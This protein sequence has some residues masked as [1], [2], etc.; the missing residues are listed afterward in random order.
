MTDDN[1]VLVYNCPNCAGDLLERSS[2]FECSACGREYP[3]LFGI[4]DF[5]TRPDRYLSLAEERAKAARLHEFGLNHSFAELL[6]FYYEITDDVP[7]DLAPSFK[8]YVW[9][10]PRRAAHILY[11]LGPIGAN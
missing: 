1:P 4:P 7:S 9:G 5:R 6:N 10:A 2:Q 8:D 3:I 11:E